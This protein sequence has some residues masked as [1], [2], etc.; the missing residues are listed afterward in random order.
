MRVEHGVPPRSDESIGIAPSLWPSAAP[1]VAS[2]PGSAPRSPAVAL[3]R[4]APATP[5]PLRY[6]LRGVLVFG[7]VV[8]LYVLAAHRGLVAWDLFWTYRWQM[9]AGACVLGLV[10]TLAIVLPAPRRA[11]LGADLYLG[12]VDNPQ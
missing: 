2:P 6:R 10:F 4:A 12:R 7:V 11:S 8:A 3:P 1:S 5:R 9:A